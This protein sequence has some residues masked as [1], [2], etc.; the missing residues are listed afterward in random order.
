MADQRGRPNVVFFFA[1]DWGR[2]ASAYRKFQGDNT[3][4][5]IVNTPNFDRIAAEGAIFTNAHVPV[6]S[7]TPCRSS[8]LSGTYFWE[9]GLGAI[10]E[11]ARWDESI[12]TYPLMLEDKGYHIGYTYKVWSPG[13]MENAPYGG[14]RT[15]YEPSG[16]KWREFSQEVTK[17]VP[18]LGVKGAK[19]V[20]FDEVRSNFLAFMDDVP[21]GDPFCYWFGPVNTHRVWERGSGKTLWGMDPDNLKGKMPDF[22]PDVHDIREDFNDYLGEVQAVD[23]G[24]GIIL[25]ELEKAGELD[26]TLIV[27]SG[28]HGIPGFPRAKCNLYDIGTQVTLAA[29]WPGKIEAGKVINE[30]VNLMSLAPTFLEAAGEKPNANMT[31]SILPLMTS[32][33][34]DPPESNYEYVVTGK[35]RHLVNVIRGDLPYPS[36]GIRT[37][38]FLYIRN[39][40]PDRWPMGDPN[41]LEDP[42]YMTDA[43]EIA[44]ISSIGTYGDSPPR[45]R[46]PILGDLDTG[47][48]KTWMIINRNIESVKPTFNLVFGKRPAEEL[49]DLQSD[50]YYMNNVAED[51]TYT[52]TLKNLSNTLMGVLEKHGDPR[53]TEEDCRFE[54]PPY[55]GPIPEEWYDTPH[56][57]GIWQVPGKK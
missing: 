26:N 46:H 9:T 13:K 14:Q 1:D 22:L 16:N 30:F 17:R 25:E 56:N 35:E 37:K 2:Y 31:H 23:A 57:D 36:R 27:I 18:E 19:E 39:F 24:V 48:T 54:N 52:D 49:Y 55:A 45:P 6:P 4:N 51:P 41:G 32:T 15:R 50:P 43:E 42:N 5:Q 8:I 34:V 40:A 11:G 44:R 38:D 12:P 53:V 33:P 7:C 47:P 10:L 21:D 28:D 3:V 20:L 29:R